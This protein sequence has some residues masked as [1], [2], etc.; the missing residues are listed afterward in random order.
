MIF[1]TMKEAREYITTLISVD[2]I[3]MLDGGTVLVVGV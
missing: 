1:P 3:T 2:Q